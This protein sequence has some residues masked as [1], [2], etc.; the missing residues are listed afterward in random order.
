MRE[1]NKS[2]LYQFLIELCPGSKIELL[3]EGWSSISFQVNEY[4]YKFSKE[5]FSD[6]EHEKLV[7]EKLKNLLSFEI[8]LIKIEKRGKYPYARYKKIK[9]ELGYTLGSVYSDQKNKDLSEKLAIDCAIFLSQVHSLIELNG[10]RSIPQFS[11]VKTSSLESFLLQYYKENI[12]G[13]IVKKYDE[14]V[15]YQAT[16]LVLLHADFYGG[17][18]TLN[19]NG[20]LKG[21]FDWCNGGIGER[22]FD[23]VPLYMHHG[24]KFTEFVFQKYNFYSEKKVDTDRVRDLVWVRFLNRLY[25]SGINEKAKLFV[26]FNLFCRQNGYEYGGKDIDESIFI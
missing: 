9:G 18:F 7:C 24:K 15:R 21:I 23:F 6:Y 12:V 20:G 1:Y 13:Q 22:M 25:F 19:E 2:E 26:Q 8:P 14:I 16:D 5:N 10:I 4:I 3:G 11:Q 17:N